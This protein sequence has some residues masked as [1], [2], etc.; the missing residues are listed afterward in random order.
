MKNTTEPVVFCHGLFGWG[1]DKLGGYPY[2]LSVH[3]LLKKHPD[4]FPPC[5]FPSTGPISSIHDQACE[6]FYQL[7]GARVHY[8]A[9]HARTFGHARYGRDYTGK[10]L[11][12]AWNADNPLDFVCHSMGAP[13]VRMLQYLL[14]EGFFSREDGTDYHTGSQWIRSITTVSG[15]HNGS[16]LTWILGVDPV[17]GKINKESPGVKIL[18]GILERYARLQAKQPGVAR[19]YDLMLDQWGIA[20]GTVEREQMNRLLEDTAYIDSCDNALHDLTPNAMEKINPQLIEYPDTWYFSHVTRSTIPFGRIS[21]PVP[22]WTH[23]FLLPPALAMGMRTFPDE[24][25]P[26]GLQRLWRAN[27][28]MCNAWSQDGPKLGR[29]RPAIAKR[30]SRWKQKTG[31]REKGIWHPMRRSRKYDHGEVAMLPHF[32][33]RQ[34]LMRYYVFIFDTIDRIRLQGRTNF[35]MR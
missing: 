9:E 5:L 29:D 15:V 35:H 17:T 4:K 21:V 26:K 7:I 3:R 14:E 20:P 19:F 23:L 32:F 8:G 12:P 31:N 22:Y 18:V 28:G 1:A 34:A 11:Y 6:L 24:A 10:S 2:F 16:T 30:R 13:V 27:D 33:R 25:L